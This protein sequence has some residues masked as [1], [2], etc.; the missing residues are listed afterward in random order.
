MIGAA[1]AGSAQ[2]SAL[3]A[4][5]EVLVSYLQSLGAAAASSAGRTQCNLHDVAAAVAE[6]CRLTGGCPSAWDHR[7]GWRRPPR[8]CARSSGSWRRW[9]RSPSPSRYAGGSR[10]RGGGGAPGSW[11]GSRQP[12]T[13]RR[14]SRRSPNAWRKSVRLQWW[15]TS[16]VRRRRRGERLI[17]RGRPGVCR[18]WRRRGRG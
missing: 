16:A 13:Y 3:D 12:R 14:G 7:P 5:A 18:R 11:G 10:R 17:S 4:L 15:R 1:M 2:A 6:L 8:R 9:R